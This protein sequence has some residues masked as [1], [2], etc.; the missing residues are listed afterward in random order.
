MTKPVLLAYV[1]L[2]S[3]PRWKTPTSPPVAIHKRIFD[4]I[5][6][7]DNTTAIITPDNRITD[8]KDILS[9]AEYE[10]M[11]PDIRTDHITKRMYLSFTLESTHTIS[12][13]K[14]GSKYDDT[15]GMFDTLR[16]T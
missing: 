13:L 14:Y 8:S 12:Q 6:A 9:G 11:F 3:V 1:H 10:K 15:T 2:I 4:V 16:E 7:I 5:K